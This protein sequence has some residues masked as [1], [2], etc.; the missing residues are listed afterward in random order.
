MTTLMTT[1]HTRFSRILN[2]KDQKFSMI[3]AH[4]GWKGQIDLIDSEKLLERQS[5]FVFILHRVDTQLYISYVTK[6]HTVYHVPFTIGVQGK[7]I[8]RNGYGI[9]SD[10]LDDFIALA[11]HTTKECCKPF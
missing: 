6:K 7:L 8:Y 9:I 5:P 3:Q 2:T 4:N 1:N 10:D 11:M